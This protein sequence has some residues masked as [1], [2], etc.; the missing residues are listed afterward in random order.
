ME[1]LKK[2]FNVNYA[3]H[4]LIASMIGNLTVYGTLTEPGDT[5]MTM[6]QPV[7]GHS[8]NRS[9]G[10]AGIRGL[11][12][13]DI[14]FDS[15][16]LTVDLDAFAEKAKAIQPKLVTLGASMTLFPISEFVRWLTS[17]LNGA[18]KFTLMVL[19]NSDCWRRILPRP[20]ERRSR[21]NHRFCW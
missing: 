6:S 7:G 19:T 3:D 5:V 9:D 17:C 11:K 4:R 20:F 1:L 21:R 18:E 12:I 2:A 10:P 13:E 16:E 8:S 14:P 15:H